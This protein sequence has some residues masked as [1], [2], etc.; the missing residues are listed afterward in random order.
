MKIAAFIL[1]IFSLIVSTTTTIWQIY[2]NT[3]NNRIN[4]KSNVCEKIYDE[5]L[6]KKIPETRKFIQIDK[7]GNFIGAEQLKDTIVNMIKDSLYFRY[8]DESFFRSIEEKLQSLEDLLVDNI[9]KKIDSIKY[10]DIINN[11]ENKIRE[12]YKLIEEKK[13]KG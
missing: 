3:K 2:S 5:Y 4:L 6:I 9:N 1:S 8:N 11:I 7:E 12:I 10:C 13:I